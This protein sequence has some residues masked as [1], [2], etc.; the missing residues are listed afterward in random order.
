M[1]DMKK[2]T[3]E[4][5]RPFDPLQEAMRRI[6]EAER[7][8]AS[9]LRLSDLGFGP[10]LRPYWDGWERLGRLDELRFLYLDNNQIIT[11]PVEGWD[12]LGHLAG[13]CWL[14]L[15]DN[16]LTAIPAEGWAALERLG[17]LTALDLSRNRL[18][19]IQSVSWETLGRMTRLKYLWLCSRIYG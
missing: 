18:T 14:D 4:G 16:Q 11:I 5:S 2:G 13:L 19:H 6:E 15:S 10:V 3:D 17:D 1:A 12:A 7:T 8:S 9:D